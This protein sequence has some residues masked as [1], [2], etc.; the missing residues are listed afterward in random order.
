VRACDKGD[1]NAFERHVDEARVAR[2]KREPYSRQRGYIYL[3]KCNRIGTHESRPRARRAPSFYG[4]RDIEIGHYCAAVKTWEGRGGGRFDG[5]RKK[6]I[7]KERQ[8]GG[9]GERE[10]KSE[11][12]RSPTHEPRQEG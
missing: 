9:E 7:E 8:G 10:E 2:E 11:K 6:E 3:R 4:H 1:G 5:R 12:P